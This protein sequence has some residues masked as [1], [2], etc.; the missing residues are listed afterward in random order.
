MNTPTTETSEIKTLTIGSETF[1][2]APL[3]MQQIE[4]WVDPPQAQ[5]D[6]QAT[7]ARIW[8]T[9]HASIGNAATLDGATEPTLDELK[10]KVS[11]KGYLALH[12]KALEASYLRDETEDTE[13][14]SAVA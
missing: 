3:S 1:R 5:L 11:L 2:F 8:G 13:A 7:R 4:Q 12:R 14:G 6:H 10:S 9:I